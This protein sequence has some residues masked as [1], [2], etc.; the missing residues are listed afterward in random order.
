[1]KKIHK[2]LILFLIIFSIALLSCNLETNTT[3][4][5]S[6]DNQIMI[7]SLTLTDKYGNDGSSI[8]RGNTVLISVSVKNY[9]NTYTLTYDLKEDTGTVT[10]LSQNTALFTSPYRDGT[11]HVYVYATDNKN[12]S[13]GICII[14]VINH[15]PII[16]TD[17]I[18]YLQA[19]NGNNTITI[20]VSDPDTDPATTLNITTFCDSGT[21][22]NPGGQIVNT[23]TF[24][25]VWTPN[26]VTNATTI[27]V[28]ITVTDDN[29]NTENASISFY[30][31][32]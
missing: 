17:N 12:T 22:L 16:D 7:S 13:T 23:G 24:T 29:P 26:G 4:P 8:I 30:Y 27:T 14:D 1:M 6:E 31:N 5:D 18:S 20:P 3:F 21:L 19:T 28:W 2:I 15:Q 32:P 9:D 11:Y 10:P 25:T